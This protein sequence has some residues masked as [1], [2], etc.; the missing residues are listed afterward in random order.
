MSWKLSRIEIEGENSE[1]FMKI[2]S[3]WSSRKDRVQRDGIFKWWELNWGLFGQTK[4][5]RAS[6]EDL[7]NSFLYS[8]IIAL[9]NLTMMRLRRELSREIESTSVTPPGGSV[10]ML[11]RIWAVEMWSRRN[12]Q[13]IGD[14]SKSLI[15]VLFCVIS[16]FPVWPWKSLKAFFC[17][18]FKASLVISSG[19]TEQSQ[20]R[21]ILFS[22]PYN[23]LPPFSMTPTQHTTVEREAE[24]KNWNLNIR[25]RSLVAIWD[26]PWGLQKRMKKILYSSENCKKFML[27]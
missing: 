20:N 10:G 23:I 2:N 18:E 4:C 6:W 7:A 15:Q 13:K 24:S 12:W 11:I 16:H 14:L 9:C 8:H 26:S 27:D 21:K 22:C 5:W 19:Q 25:H 1:N 17:H 3:M